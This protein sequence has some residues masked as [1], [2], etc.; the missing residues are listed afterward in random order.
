MSKFLPKIA[1]SVLFFLALSI[2]GCEKPDEKVDNTNPVAIGVIGPFSGPD[3]GWGENGLLGVETAI[4]LEKTQGNRHSLK[5]IKEDDQSNPKLTIAALDKLVREDQVSAVLVLSSSSS[6]LAIADLADSYKTPIVSV[7]A[8]HPDI[9]GNHWVSQFI[10]D[11]VVQGNVAALY[12]ID[13]LFIDHVGVGRDENDPHGESLADH[14]VD[15]FKTAGGITERIDL[16]GDSVNYTDLVVQLR[17]KDLDFIYLPL[18]AAKVIEFERAARQVGWNPQVMVSD[19]L[20]AVMMLEYEDDLPIIEGMLATDI[21]AT[22]AEFTQYGKR[23]S[24]IFKGSFKEPGTTISALGCEATSALI[25]ALQN[26]GKD[27]DKTCINLA[28]RGGNEFPGILDPILIHR[29]GKAERPVF[30][31]TIENSKLQPVLRVN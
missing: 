25:T 14:F 22:E 10:F 7:L 30:I 1:I 19:G 28:L 24:E 23:V 8:S 6:M 20:L 16:T 5:I 9:T 11:D 26:C 4:Q 13:E 2:S 12:V 31:N 21:F 18:Q 3:K 27:P 17:D 29:S 15:R